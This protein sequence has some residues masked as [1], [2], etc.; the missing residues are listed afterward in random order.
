MVTLQILVLSFLVRIQVAQLSGRGILDRFF[1]ACTVAS[2]VCFT[3]LACT[4]ATLFHLAVTA[5]AER[6]VRSLC[7]LKGSSQAELAK[8]SLRVFVVVDCCDTR[9]LNVLSS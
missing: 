4:V 6:A 3:P 7:E 5:N 9:P 1:C 2:W 8:G